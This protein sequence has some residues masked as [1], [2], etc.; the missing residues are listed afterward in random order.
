V[1]CCKIK[2]KIGLCS[3]DPWRIWETLEEDEIMVD[4]ELHELLENLHQEIERIESIDEKDQELLRDL[5]KDITDLLERS[6]KGKTEPHP[7]TL[8]KLEDSLDYFE[9][10]HPD[11]TMI[12]AKLLDT[13]SNSGI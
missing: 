6:E 8:Q 9:V 11:L 7:S 13:L 4:P 2:V 5:S 1:D 12:I 10:T 3:P